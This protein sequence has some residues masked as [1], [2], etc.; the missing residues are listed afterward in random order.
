MKQ[1]VTMPALSDTMSV[2]RLAKWLKQP[3]EAVHKG[4]AIA[5]IET[6][7]A[8]MDVEAFYD[9]YLAGPLASVD[10][11]L[12]LGATIGFIVDTPGEAARGGAAVP[13]P[14]SATVVTPAAHADPA[15]PPEPTSVVRASPYARSLARNL[16]VDLSNVPVT[17]AGPIDSATLLGQIGCSPAPNVDDGPLRHMTRPSPLRDAVA[18]GMIASVATPTFRVTALLPLEP[19]RKA[20]TETGYS[21]ALLLAR[22]CALTIEA[23]PLFNAIYAPDGLA[24]RE[25]VDIGIAVDIPEGLVSPVLRDVA[26]RPLAELARD[27]A[28]LRDKLKT[29]RLA[30]QDY[31]GATFYLSDLGVFPVVYSFDA[32]IPVGASAILAVAAAM[33]GGA[34]CTLSCDHRVVFGADA[35]RFLTTLNERIADPRQLISV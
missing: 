11:D 10:T 18:R 34:M 21:L 9:G 15:V 1:A 24:Q 26:R 3:G 6:D 31:R 33:N 23:H 4:E 5:E 13:P 30:A 20:A 22:A 27:W 2:G 35:A 16:G 32:L 19:L 17:Q 29:R 8:V 28:A 25:R 14:A 7:K 12:P